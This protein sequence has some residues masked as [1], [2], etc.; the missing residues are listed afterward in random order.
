MNAMWQTS[1]SRVTGS[2]TLAVSG[3]VG[4]P[5]KMSDPEFDQVWGLTIVFLV[6][7]FAANEWCIFVKLRKTK[8]MSSELNEINLRLSKQTYFLSYLLGS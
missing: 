6:A 3:L 5:V 4:L 1:G 2:T 7:L 8:M